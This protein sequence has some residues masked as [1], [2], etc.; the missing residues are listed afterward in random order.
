MLNA[1]LHQQTINHH[2]DGVISSF[3]EFEIVVKIHQ[4]AVDTGTAITV[5]QQRLHLFLEFAFAPAHNRRQHHHAIFRS[6][7]HDAL[8]YLIGRLAADRT[9]AIRTM[10]H[11]NRGEQE[12]KIIVDFSD[13]TYGG[14]RTAAG[15][16]LFDG[17]RRTKAVNGVNVRAF[18]LIEELAGV[19]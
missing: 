17:D 15:G 11:P 19:G 2:L 16:F 8:D 12:A 7:R 3:V 9:A 10:R 13:G 6:E 18:H 4:S 1:G 5:L 14:A